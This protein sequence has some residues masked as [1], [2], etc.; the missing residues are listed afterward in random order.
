[1]N[2]SSPG[3]QKALRILR[4]ISSSLSWMKIAVDVGQSVQR[5]QVV[6][7]VGT[8]GITTGPHVHFEVLVGGAKTNPGNYLR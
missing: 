1:M 5:G 8:T 2:A 4:R 3:G 7:Y 6:G